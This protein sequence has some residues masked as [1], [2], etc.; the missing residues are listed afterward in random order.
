[1]FAPSHTLLLITRQVLARIDLTGKRR[2]KIKQVWTQSSCDYEVLTSELDRA[3]KLGPRPGRLT[4]LSPDYWTDVLSIPADVAA[5]ANANETLQALALEAEVD[6]GLSAFDSRTAAIRLDS[7]N[8]DDSQWCTTQI[9]DTQLREL[10][11]FAKS[12]RTRFLA[13][14]HPV[15]AQFAL[16]DTAT[17]EQVT[18]W[19]Q[20]WREQTEFTADQLAELA[21]QWA[22]CLALT[23]RCPL[24]IEEVDSAATSQPFAVTASLALLAMGGCALWHW[25]TQQCLASAAQAIEALEKKQNQHECHRRL[26]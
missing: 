8:T 21:E 18:A 17:A 1:M 6:S 12:H 3:L 14:A 2:L 20:Q 11:D 26:R 13:A 9:P 25:Q 10:S 24:L 23:P 5:I 22:N 19:L 4:V 7:K 15:T 16:L